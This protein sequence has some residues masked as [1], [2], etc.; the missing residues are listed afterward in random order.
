[1]KESRSLIMDLLTMSDVDF[2]E[3]EGEEDRIR[4]GSLPVVLP[5]FRIFLLELVR[6]KPMLITEIERL[7][8]L[9]RSLRLER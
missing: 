8:M 1:M 4:L 2:M 3:R 5:V 9:P 6:I 7:I